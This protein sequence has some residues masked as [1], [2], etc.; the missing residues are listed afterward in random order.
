MHA[1]LYEK[2]IFLLFISNFQIN[3]FSYMISTEFNIWFAVQNLVILNLKNRRALQSGFRNGPINYQRTLLIAMTW[4]K[5]QWANHLTSLSAV[6]HLH[7]PSETT[8]VCLNL[9]RFS[10]FFFSFFFF[11][12]FFLVWILSDWRLP[13]SRWFDW[14]LRADCKAFVPIR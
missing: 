10:S 13:T 7:N 2:R 14:Q 5:P 6:Y 4:Q 8:R 11:L 3:L 1:I 12:F 9:R